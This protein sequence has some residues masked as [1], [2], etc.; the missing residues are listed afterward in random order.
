MRPGKFGI[1]QTSE[2]EWNDKAFEALVLDE[3]L[4]SFIRDLVAE[5]RATD[6]KSFDDIVRDKGRGLVGLLAG[7]PGVGK[8]AHPTSYIHCSGIR[9]GH[10]IKD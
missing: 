10:L 8:V 4:K 5:H 1:G 7:P 3:D 9:V 2:V 6:S